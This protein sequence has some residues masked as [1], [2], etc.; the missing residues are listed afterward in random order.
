M[1]FF[2]YGKNLWH[3]RHQGLSKIMLSFF[4]EAD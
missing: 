4:T 1:A 2:E 3:K